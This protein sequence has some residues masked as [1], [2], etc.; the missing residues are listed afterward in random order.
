M[1]GHYIDEI[2]S[3]TLSKDPKMILTRSLREG[4]KKSDFRLTEKV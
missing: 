1:Q 2:L 4:L 3:F